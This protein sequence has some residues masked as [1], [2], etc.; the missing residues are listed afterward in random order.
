MIILNTVSM[1]VGSL[2]RRITMGWW[3]S[4]IGLDFQSTGDRK[5]KRPTRADAQS[6]G[7]QALDALESKARLAREH[8]DQQDIIHRE[9]NSLREQL[10]LD[11][12][13]RVDDEQRT[14]REY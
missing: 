14:R 10:Q 2:K 9:Q 13:R 6:D 3:S 5:N 12:A 7:D 1:D 11:E 4:F 8:Q